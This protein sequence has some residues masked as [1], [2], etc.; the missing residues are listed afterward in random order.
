[1]AIKKAIPFRLGFEGDDL[2]TTLTADTA[3]AAFIL[4]TGVAGQV[5]P[6]FSI[7]TTTPT[8]VLNP[9]TSS[10]GTVTASIL[11]GVV[12][13]TFSMAPPSGAYNVIDGTFTF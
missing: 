8:G 13:F 12:T 9:S 3:T 10:S 1:M 11:A 6:G 7:T 5:S 4:S 2:S